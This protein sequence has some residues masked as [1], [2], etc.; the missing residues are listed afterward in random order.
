MIMEKKG[1]RKERVAKNLN[2][3]EWGRDPPKILE[4]LRGHVL[5]LFW[6]LRPQPELLVSPRYN[7]TPI[8]P[9]FRASIL[10]R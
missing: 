8:P 7:I 6:M 1:K 10:F 5:Y 3:L 9:I 2:G 4:R